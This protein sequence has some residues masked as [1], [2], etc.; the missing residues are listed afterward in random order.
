MPISADMLVTVILGARFIRDSTLAEVSCELSCELS[1][2]R[3][4]AACLPTTTGLGNRAM[5]DEHAMRKWRGKNPHSALGYNTPSAYKQWFLVAV[6]SDQPA[7]INAPGKIKDRTRNT[8][9][10]KR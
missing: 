4:T 10:W 3:F 1:C 6:S 8:S 5:S 7:H 9:T 2:E